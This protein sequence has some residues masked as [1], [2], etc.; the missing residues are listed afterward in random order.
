MA[1]RLREGVFSVA[2]SSCAT[3]LF[4][5]EVDVSMSHRPYTEI[6]RDLK[7]TLSKVAEAKNPKDKQRLLLK[8]R[9]LLAE[10]DGN[11]LESS[12]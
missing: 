12:D 9:L 3:S 2:F 5:Q 10:A 11:I 4:K 7:E 8:M 6:E 1:G